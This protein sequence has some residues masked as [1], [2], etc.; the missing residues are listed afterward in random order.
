M[1]VKK[2]H[3]SWSWILMVIFITLSIVDIRFG[4]LGFICMGAPIYHALRGEGKIHCSKYC[5]RGS[6]LGKFL[7]LVSFN[8]QLPKAFRGRKAKNILLS[9]MM[10]MFTISLYH[11]FH[12]PNVIKAVAFAVF[13]LMMVSFVLGIIMGVIF[14]PRSWCQVCPM[15][16]GTALIKESQDKKASKKVK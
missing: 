5:P 6:I 15:G 16:H 14:K 3:Q 7:Q 13:R 4:L 1:A 9:I 8:N 10:I 11:A 2:S 12:Q